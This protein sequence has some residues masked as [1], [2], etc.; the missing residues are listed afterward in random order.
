MCGRRPG[1]NDWAKANHFNKRCSSKHWGV[2]RTPRKEQGSHFYCSFSEF[3]LNILS[4]SERTSNNH[5]QG[6]EDSTGIFSWTWL[7]EAFKLPMHFRREEQTIRD[8]INPFSA[9]KSPCFRFHTNKVSSPR[10]IYLQNVQ[11]IK[12]TMCTEKCCLQK[13]SL[14]HTNLRRE[15]F[16]YLRNKKMAL[17]TCVIFKSNEVYAEL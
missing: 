6:K 15:V 3:F 10:F 4:D 2:R 16:A 14:L 11:T 13:W 7:K 12:W 5:W 9:H 8:Q 17:V 1:K